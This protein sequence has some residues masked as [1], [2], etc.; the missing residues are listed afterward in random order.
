MTTADRLLSVL[1]L[2]TLDEPEWTVERAAQ[3]LDM[4]TSTAYRYFNSLRGVGFLDSLSAG[5]YVLGPAIVEYDRQIRILDPLLTVARP[6]MQRI[7][8]L[9]EG[10]AIVLLCRRYR[11]KVMCV[12]QE[13]AKGVEPDVSYERG[14]PLALFRGA[15]SRVILGNLAARTLKSVYAKY[16]EE[17]K[18]AGLGADWEDFRRRNKSVRARDSL[19][20]HGELDV[21][22]VGVAAAIFHPKDNVIGS[23][24]ATLHERDSSNQMMARM[25]AV[26]I[27]AAREIEAA[28]ADHEKHITALARPPASP[29]R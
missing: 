28:L 19:T 26:V 1:Q 5:A 13:F 9:S 15:P 2:F 21:G 23:I 3:Q 17:I 6:I 20:S 14:R 10:K 4:S 12:H 29:D 18:A 25:G 8:E 11:Q 22:R 16:P 7:V 27:A 24:S